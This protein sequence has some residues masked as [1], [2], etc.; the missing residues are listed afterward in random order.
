MRMDE[1]RQRIEGELKDLGAKIE[2]KEPNIINIIIQRDNAV[3]AARRLSSIGF[4]HVKAVTAVDRGKE[5]E[6]IYIVSSYS[7]DISYFLVKLRISLS[8]DDLR[9]PS[10]VDIW[11]SALYQEHEEHEMMGIYFEGHPRMGK[12]LLLPESYEGIPPL[13]KEF[14]IKTEGIDHEGA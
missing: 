4:D 11:P 10:L 2:A 7:E 12:K 3:E 1:L 14:K 6:V 5:F 8:H 13:R 9:T